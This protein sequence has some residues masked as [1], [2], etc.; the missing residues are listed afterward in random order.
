MKFQVLGPMALYLVLSYFAP[1]VVGFGTS[2]LR[3]GTT[4]QRA[5]AGICI[6]VVLLIVAVLARTAIH[7]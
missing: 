5:A 4:E 3:H 6:A 1:V 7:Q 2:I